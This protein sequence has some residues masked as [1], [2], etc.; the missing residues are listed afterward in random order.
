MDHLR[1]LLDGDSP[2]RIAAWGRKTRFEF[3]RPNLNGAIIDFACGHRARVE[4]GW[5]LPEFPPSEWTIIGP[6]GIAW[7]DAV[8]QQAHLSCASGR[9]TVASPEDWFVSCFR[10]QL[11]AFVDAIRTGQ[12]PRPSTGDGIASLELTHLFERG[13]ETPLHPLEIASA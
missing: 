4:I 8:T 1:Y 11:A 3:P 2:V 7:F 5:F 12:T 13:M 6:D 9:E 10:H